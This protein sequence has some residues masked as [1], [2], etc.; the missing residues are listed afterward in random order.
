MFI[1]LFIYILK[2]PAIRECAAE[3]LRACLELIAE[4]ESRMRLQWYQKI[5][6]EAFRVSF[7]SSSLITLLILS[8]S[9]HLAIVIY[10]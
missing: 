8:Y 7:F 6:D 2:Q 5:Y 1:Y 10:Y 4:R 9:L 3:A